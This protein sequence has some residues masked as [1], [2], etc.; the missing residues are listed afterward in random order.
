MT[1]M[2]RQKIHIEQLVTDNTT[3]IKRRTKD[4]ITIGYMSDALIL[5]MAFHTQQWIAKNDLII[6]E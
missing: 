2:Y 4:K 3:M 6:S 1:E 5:V